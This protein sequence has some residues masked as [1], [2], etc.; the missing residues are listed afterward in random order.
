MS[1][2]LALTNPFRHRHT[3]KMRIMSEASPN[4]FSCRDSLFPGFPDF[5]HFRPHGHRDTSEV[6]LIAPGLKW[7]AL[8]RATHNKGIEKEKMF[9]V[10]KVGWI[11][12]L[13][14]KY[15]RIGLV[16]APPKK[17]HNTMLSAQH[18]KFPFPAQ[19]L[20]CTRAPFIPKS[21]YVDGSFRISWWAVNVPHYNRRRKCRHIR[22]KIPLRGNNPVCF[23][24]RI[25][26]SRSN[27]N[28]MAFCYKSL[29]THYR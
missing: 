6:Y 18:H 29:F 11:I 25:T 28:P 22:T 27:L 8:K 26:C 3:S 1:S 24:F 10:I 7:I 2:F 13:F 5:G 4:F 23:L 14:K 9:H 20:W 17:F 21:F 12:L 19:A 16:K 15:K